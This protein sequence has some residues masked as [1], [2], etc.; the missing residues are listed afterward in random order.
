MFELIVAHGFWMQFLYLSMLN[1]HLW[2]KFRESCILIMLEPW[3]FS[4]VKFKKLLMDTQERWTKHIYNVLF[5]L[6]SKS[7]KTCKE[8]IPACIKK[9]KFRHKQKYKYLAIVNSSYQSN[10]LTI[11]FK[12]IE[13]VSSESNQTLISNYMKIQQILYNLSKCLFQG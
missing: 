4:Y 6:D 9:R 12:L 1:L 8:N 3:L 13:V 2:L 7:N 11:G 10:M 5:Y